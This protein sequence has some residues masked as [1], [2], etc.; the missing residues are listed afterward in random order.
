MRYSSFKFEL[1]IR[2]FTVIPKVFA[3]TFLNSNNFIF[4]KDRV[5]LFGEYFRK[6]KTIIHV[7][8]LT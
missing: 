6:I 8:L 1:K 3:L 5:N 7:K 4:N 2:Q